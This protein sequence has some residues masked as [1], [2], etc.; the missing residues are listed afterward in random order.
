MDTYQIVREY[1]PNATDEFCEMLIWERTGY[2]CFWN[3]PECGKTPEECFRNQ[4]KEVFET[5][6]S[7]KVKHSEH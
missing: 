2:P 4:V 3:I 1:F 7:K 6:T 5:S